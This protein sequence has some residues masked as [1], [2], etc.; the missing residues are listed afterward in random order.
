M[1][2]YVNSVNGTESRRPSWGAAGCWDSELLLKRLIFHFSDAKAP[3]RN[4][5]THLIYF[6]LT[7]R[8]KHLSETKNKPPNITDQYLVSRLIIYTIF[9]CH[10]SLCFHLFSFISSQVDISWVFRGII[11]SRSDL[12][13]SVQFIPHLPKSSTVFLFLTWHPRWGFA[14]AR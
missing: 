8:L 3:K 9:W 6:V 11:S 7:I 2:F 13:P 1:N 14:N 4:E 12:P 10:S 5:S